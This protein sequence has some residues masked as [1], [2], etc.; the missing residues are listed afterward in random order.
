MRRYRS[1]IQSGA[2]LAAHEYTVSR[3]LHMHPLSSRK[4][5][6]GSGTSRPCLRVQMRVRRSPL[7]WALNVWM[8]LF[9]F[10]GVSFASFA[11]EVT[12][13]ANRLSITITLWLVLVAYRFT[14]MDNLPKTNCVTY[15]DVYCQS[16]FL[17]C[18]AVSVHAVALAVRAEVSLPEL[19]LSGGASW[20]QPI[21]WQASQRNALLGCS[22][23]WLSL[24]LILPLAVL[25]QRYLLPS[26]RETIRWWDAADN[27]LWFR[28]ISSVY[29]VSV[30]DRD[31]L[32][33]F[34]LAC[35]PKERASRVRFKSITPYCDPPPGLVPPSPAKSISVGGGVFAAARSSSGG[36]T[37]RALL[38]AVRS[39]GGGGGGGS[40]SSSTDVL[41]TR[42]S[43]LKQDSMTHDRHE[44]EALRVHLRKS[45]STL[46]AVLPVPRNAGWALLELE[47]ADTAKAV[48]KVLAD[49]AKV[50][51]AERDATPTPLQAL[52]TWI[53]D[54]WQRDGVE[55]SSPRM[56]AA[57]STDASGA[58]K[59]DFVVEIALPE[60]KC[61]LSRPWWDL[62]PET[63]EEAANLQAQSEKLAA[64]V[65]EAAVPEAAAPDEAPTAHVAVAVSRQEA[66]VHE[67]KHAAVAVEETA[68]APSAMHPAEVDEARCAAAAADVGHDTRDSDAEAASPAEESV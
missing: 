14:L 36:L 27:V 23:A 64:A 43:S 8:P 20:A 58:R 10:T 63:A 42:A 32:Q 9:C 66:V 16:C 18:F 15:L 47:H 55:C 40:S 29:E 24:N 25:V 49:A 61:L 35:M 11:V 68:A 1:V 12:A 26:G 2:L 51:L 45:A 33:K 56:H 48:C 38:A 37:P 62:A 17:V 60:Y 59:P 28:G 57:R 5:E 67:A 65:S 39:S 3:I 41:R 54:N 44:R 21:T 53:R 7:F 31:E 19:A 46:A 30:A 13:L 4:E 50:T 52:N 22:I 34:I 6:S